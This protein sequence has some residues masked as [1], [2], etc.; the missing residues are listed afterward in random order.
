[1]A[2]EK[3]KGI[4]LQLF[5]A[6]AGVGSRRACEPLIQSGRVAVNGKVV[7]E[8]GTRVTEDD[9]VV[10]DGKELRPVR[11]KVY[12]ALHKPVGYICAHTDDEN[13]PIVYDL[14]RPY[15]SG[16]LFSVGRLDFQTSGLLL[17]TN[18][19]EFAK[20]VAHPS[21][22]IEKEYVVETKKPISED[23][24]KEWIAGIRIAG[25]KYVLKRYYL[26]TSRRI[27]LVLEE[28]KNREIRT[29][30]T[31]WRHSV[32]RIH[33]VRIGAVVMKDLPP[34]AHREL[35][36]TEI[37]SLTRKKPRKLIIRKKK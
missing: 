18:D 29:V 32:K 34:A 8:L 13:R 31:F 10:F 1:M 12:F 19:G 11:R 21:S 15:F 7:T 20:T 27:H 24:L 3:E 5:L 9:L 4:R 22:R 14:I 36:P 17:L 16:R 35:T 30:F 23:R 26:K 2:E 25:E 6:R 28:G 37:A 33:R